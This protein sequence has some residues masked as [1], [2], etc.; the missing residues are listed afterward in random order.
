MNSIKGNVEN[1]QGQIYKN[2][3]VQKKKRNLINQ[4]QLVLKKKLYFTNIHVG[5]KNKVNIVMLAAVKVN[6]EG[7]LRR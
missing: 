7:K 4:V 5:L 2:G 3:M 6:Y 1:K